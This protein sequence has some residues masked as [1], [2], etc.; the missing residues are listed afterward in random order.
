M[1]PAGRWLTACQ[2]PR[3]RHH[4]ADPMSS[5]ATG[6]RST[7]ALLQEFSL[8][9][10]MGVL[11][12]LLLANVDPHGYHVL[13]HWSP[14][15]EHSHLNF[16]FIVN[17]LF[18]ALFFGV[19][20][21]EI[22]EACLPGGALNPPRK[23][24]NPLAGTLG[25]VLGPVGVYFVIVAVTGDSEITRGWGVPTAT[26]IAL[27]WLVARMVFGAGH[28]AVA[29]LLLLAVAD[30]AI[31]LGII[32]VFYGDPLNPA[33]P[34]Y[35]LLVVAAMGVAWALKRK[36]VKSF[37]PYVL[38]AGPLSWSGFF[39]S[40]LHPALALVPVVPFMPNMG[41]DEGLFREASTGKIYPD[42]LNSFEHFFKKP[43]DFGLL[44]FGVA[45]A[46]VEF[47]SM[48]TATWA[49]FISLMVG[50]T[51]G[52]SLCSIVAAR[53]GFPLPTGM[54]LKTL[55]VAGMTAALGLTVALFVAGVAF[56]D[57]TLQGSAKM[58]ALLSAM[59]APVALLM[60]RLLRVKKIHASAQ[61]GGHH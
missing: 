1:R 7:V 27:A 33:R 51:F 31:G 56:V 45:N 37:W 2:R 40:H 23:A 12:G 19:A 57:P 36:G 16:H 22:T 28:P 18:M 11:L 17:D 52:I 4:A 14:L 15:G 26:D 47:S 20:A 48:G 41:F 34:I 46:G 42:T 21:K 61:G 44:A 10:L 3:S 49:V 60:G 43:V 9:L 54:D 59:A 53:L 24:V 6:R 5:E 35:M 29:F 38:I 50:K 8:P 55:F 13:L 39:L 30:D 25:G 58:G 32:A